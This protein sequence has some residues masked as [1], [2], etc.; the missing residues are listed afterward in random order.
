MAAAEEVFKEEADG[1]LSR[2][3][4]KCLLSRENSAIEELLEK[5]GR[6]I[7]RKASNIS[8]GLSEKEVEEVINN[9]IKLFDDK[10]TWYID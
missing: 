5:M 3:L 1:A 10:L 6:M 9:N 7:G 2:E 4:K 8:S